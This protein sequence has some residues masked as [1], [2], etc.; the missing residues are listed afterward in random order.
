MSGVP[1]LLIIGGIVMIVVG[2]LWMAGSKFFHLQ[3]GRLPGD[4]AV[5]K[6]N[7]RF[8]F[9]VVTCIILSVVLSLG[10]YIIRWF[11]K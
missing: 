2:L 6:E 3:L 5:E 4:I 8:Y 11:M 7:V 9:P 1:K 10:M